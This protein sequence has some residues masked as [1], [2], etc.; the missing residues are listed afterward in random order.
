MPT[1]DPLKLDIGAGGHA[2]PGFT[3]VDLYHPSADVKDDLLTLSQFSDNTIAWVNTAHVLEH[4]KNDDLPL[5]F[6]SVYRILMPG[7]KW[8]IEVPDLVWILEDFLR[9]PEPKRW[10]WKLQTIFGLQSNQGEYHKTGFS[11]ERLGH[12]LVKSGFTNIKVNSIY[13][14]TYNQGVIRATAYKP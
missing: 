4:I 7:G 8:T 13:S 14:K 11:Q 6:K 10:G 12:N 3:T 9:T 2:K 1:K 5:V